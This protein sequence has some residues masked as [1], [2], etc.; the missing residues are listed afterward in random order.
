M[1]IESYGD[2]LKK[3]IEFAEAK[4]GKGLLPGDVTTEVIHEFLDFLAATGYRKRNGAASR[5]KRLVTI[6]TFFR[7]LHREGLVGRD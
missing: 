5:A 4:K 7:Y 6:R 3:F 2:D 1:P